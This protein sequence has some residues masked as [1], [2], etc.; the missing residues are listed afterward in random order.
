MRDSP[1]DPQD[2][3]SPKARRLVCKCSTHAVGIFVPIHFVTN[4]EPVTHGISLQAVFERH[5]CEPSG[6]HVT[7]TGPI[8]FDKIIAPEVPAPAS[9]P[10]PA[11]PAAPARD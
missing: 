10:P 5:V 2:Q 11:A 1:R 6:Q 7:I 8:V 3:T 9:L 4:A